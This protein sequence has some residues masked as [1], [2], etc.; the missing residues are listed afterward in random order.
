[1]DDIKIYTLQNC[2]YCGQVK[3]HLKNKGISFEEIVITENA[4]AKK[5][6]K[7]R[8]YTGVP[9]TVIGSIEILGPNLDKIDS[10]LNQNK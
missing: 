3:K 1:M 10:A 6:M 8:G 5:F 4:D 2:G 7:E 9:V